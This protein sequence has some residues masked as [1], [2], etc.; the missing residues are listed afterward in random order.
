[1]P[2]T[3]TPAAAAL[4]RATSAPRWRP[5]GRAPARPPARRTSSPSHSAPDQSSSLYLNV[6]LPGLSSLAAAPATSWTFFSGILK[7]APPSSTSR[8]SSE[9]QSANPGIQKS[10]LVAVPSIQYIH[11]IYY[12]PFIHYIPFCMKEICD[13]INIIYPVIL[14]YI[15]R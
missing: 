8:K 6:P 13:L 4:L 5:S 7:A 11:Y 2:H 10:H 1:M 15:K 3:S 9:I 14:S 12:K